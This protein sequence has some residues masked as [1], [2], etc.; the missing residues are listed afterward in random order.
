MCQMGQ[1][2]DVDRSFVKDFSFVLHQSKF[3]NQFS[4]TARSN[5][6][7]LLIDSVNYDE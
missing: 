3:Q 7:F 1:K 4:D 5:K 6:W 2:E